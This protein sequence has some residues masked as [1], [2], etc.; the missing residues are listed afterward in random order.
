M[1]DGGWRMADG[2]WRMA[3]GG[4]R[5]ADGGWRMAVPF[6]TRFWMPQGGLDFLA[7]GG[8]KSRP[9]GR[10]EPWSLYDNLSGVLKGRD[11]NRYKRTIFFIW[12]L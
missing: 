4:W 5:M 8:A 1:A 6:F 9:A 12:N 11:T 2:G 7:K 10:A 3:D